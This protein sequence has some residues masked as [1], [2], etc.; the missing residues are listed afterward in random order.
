LQVAPAAVPCTPTQVLD[1]LPSTLERCG[2]FRFV[3]SSRTWT[4]SSATYAIY[5]FA[6]GE[7]VPTTEL[8]VL[9]QHDDDRAAVQ[10]FLDEVLEH[11][12]TSSVWHRICDARGR[13]R[14]AVS[15]AAGLFRSDGT[16]ALVTG[17]VV[18][19][20]EPVRVVTAH[21]V[22][23]A[24]ELIGRTRPTI[25]QA[26]GVL[27]SAYGLDAE[28]A[29]TMLRLYSQQHNV[30]VRD[31]ARELVES[32]SVVGGLPSDTR[33]ALDRLAVTVRPRIAGR[34]HERPRA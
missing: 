30:K 3:P 25:E 5:G 4:W 20:S 31:V 8:T 11:G 34:P 22:T 16:L 12:T 6:P 14:Q 17:H 10:Q 29:F 33:A 24:L 2:A 15:T 23:R 27:M 21:E 26:K 19:V 28:E 9:H 13:Q 1:V 18:D 7:V 32:V